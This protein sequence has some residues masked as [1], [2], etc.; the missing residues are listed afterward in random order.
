MDKEKANGCMHYD[1]AFKQSAISMIT[2]Q[3][4]SIK[5][6]SKE[7]GVSTDLLRTW[8]RN[9]GF[10]PKAE[11]RDNSQAKKIHE[12]ETKIRSLEKKLEHKDEVITVLK[13]SIVIICNP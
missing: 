9:Y 7:L 13:K 10:D 1:N 12:L 2:E 8:L 11:N 3:H 4:L 6:A 5:G